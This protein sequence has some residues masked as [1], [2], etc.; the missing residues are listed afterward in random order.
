ML[1]SHYCSA[2][3]P[4]PKVIEV[5]LKSNTVVKSMEKEWSS[6][7]SH[8]W[9]SFTLHFLEGTPRSLFKSNQFKPT[10]GI[11]TYQSWVNK[12]NIASSVVTRTTQTQ[13]TIGIAIY[14]H[15]YQCRSG[16]IF[17]LA[18]PHIMGQ[19]NCRDYL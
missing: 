4:S 19:R 6:P 5:C 2:D 12:T 1:I 7:R 9:L 15:T 14:E 8:Q 11:F 10:V 16:I 3:I 18:L 13:V 17:L